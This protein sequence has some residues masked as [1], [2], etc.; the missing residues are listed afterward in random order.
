MRDYPIFT[1]EMKSTHTI[2]IPNMLP[3]HFK[4]IGKVMRNYGYNVK[5]LTTTGQNITDAGLQSV[6]NDTCYPALL[7]IGQFIDAIESG[8]YNRSKLALMI[9]QTGGGC[10]ASNYIYLLRKALKKRGYGDIP[11]ISLNFTG[12]DKDSS[13]PINL[14]IGIQLLWSVLLGDL[15]MLLYNQVKPYEV[16]P[17]DTE[18]AENAAF[19]LANSLFHKDKIVRYGAV[20][21]KYSEIIDLFSKVTVDRSETKVKVGVVGEIYVKFSPLGNNNLEKFLLS[22]GAEVV[23]PGLLDFCLYC[24]AN[25]MVDRELYGGNFIKSAVFSAAFGW[26]VN[27]QRD[28]IKAVNASGKFNPPMNFKETLKNVREYISPGVKMGEGWLLTAEMI[29]LIHSG[30]SNIICTQPFGCLPNHIAG[31]GMMKKIKEM[32]PGANIVAIDYDPGATK[33]NQE[34]RIKLMMSVARRESSEKHGE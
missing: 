4:L 5:L 1:P 15:I 27:K 22:V 21:S 24:V 19:E 10:R 33:V 12:L 28:M 7:V 23:M 31:K 13:F 18:I 17:G 2:L 34:N 11:V 8:E 9:S 25:T 16:T 3:V 20:R 29:E 32:N 30:A 14:P 6:H 26:M